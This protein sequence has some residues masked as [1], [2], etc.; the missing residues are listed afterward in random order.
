MNIYEFIYINI[1]NVLNIETGTHFT[2]LYKA[3][4]MYVR[5]TGDQ[6]YAIIFIVL[7]MR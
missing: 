3:H 5:D 2:V 1:F 7:T 4:Y 6:N